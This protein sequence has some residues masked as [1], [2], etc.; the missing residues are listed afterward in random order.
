M[1]A[2]SGGYGSTGYQDIESITL[3]IK[4]CIQGCDDTPS[5]DGWLDLE[6][7]D[8]VSDQSCRWNRDGSKSGRHRKF[9]RLEKDELTTI[10]GTVVWEESD[11]R[12]TAGRYASMVK[13]LHSER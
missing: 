4:N 12:R 8:F 6:Y 1:A 10:K 7:I 11:I 5:V 2:G 13:R 9:V 3:A